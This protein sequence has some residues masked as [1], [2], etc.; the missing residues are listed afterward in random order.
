MRMTQYVPLEW[1]KDNRK[2]ITYLCAS[3]NSSTLHEQLEKTL[4]IEIEGMPAH[5]NPTEGIVHGVT[6]NFTVLSE[7]SRKILAGSFLKSDLELYELSGCSM[8]TNKKIVESP[9]GD[10]Q[11]E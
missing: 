9:R 7:K 10:T 6:A 11:L 5:H 1:I 3:S 8:F 4:G 2:S